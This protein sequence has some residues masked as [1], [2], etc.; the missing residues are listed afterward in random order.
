M[1]AALLELQ[2]LSKSFGGLAAVAELSFGVKAGTITSLILAAVLIPVYAFFFALALH[3]ATTGLATPAFASIAT[4]LVTLRPSV[5]S[6][7]PT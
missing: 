7:R 1:S 3:L 4:N 2:H 6:S 5:V